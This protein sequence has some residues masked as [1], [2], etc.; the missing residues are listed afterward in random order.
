MSSG[1]CGNKGQKCNGNCSCN[2]PQTDNSKKEPEKAVVIFGGDHL[3][4]IEQNLNGLG[5]NNIIHFSGRKNIPQ[6]NVALPPTA[7][8]V[9]VLTDYINHSI[10]GAIKSHA[11]AQNIPI[12]FA[13]RSWSHIAEKM[14]MTG[15]AI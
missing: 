1:Q 6:R 13:K 10:A 3:G 8:L 12:L 14:H 2:K 15:T 11:K 7:S 9:L 4:S 5:F